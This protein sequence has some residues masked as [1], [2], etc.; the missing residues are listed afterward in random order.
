M[1]H[2]L[3]RGEVPTGWGP[4]RER[5]HLVGITVDVRVILKWI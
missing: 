2:V 5:D 4:L 3:E 1:W